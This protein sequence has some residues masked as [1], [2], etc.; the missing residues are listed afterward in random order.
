MKGVTLAWLTFLAIQTVQW[1]RTNGPAQLPPPSLYVGSAAAFGLLGGL[2]Q[3]A[4]APASA[5]AWALIV[6]AAVTNQFATAGTPSHLTLAGG[7]TSTSKGKGKAATGPVGP[8]GPVGPS[9]K[10]N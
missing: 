5:M 8:M 2:A 3:V 7:T 4:P 1:E 9:T 6:A 10:G